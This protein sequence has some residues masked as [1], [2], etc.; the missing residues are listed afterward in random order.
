MVIGRPL[1]E[2]ITWERRQ[3]TTSGMKSWSGSNSIS[4]SVMIH[5]PPGRS[6]PTRRWKRLRR[7]V[8]IPAWALPCSALGVAISMTSLSMTWARMSEGTRDAPDRP[9]SITL[10]DGEDV[11]TSAALP[12][13]ASIASRAAGVGLRELAG[14]ETALGR[15]GSGSAGRN[16]SE[17]PDMA[18]G[19]PGKLG[20]MAC[21]SDAEALG[22]GGGS[23]DD[24]RG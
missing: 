13:G 21:G 15:L 23:A 20:G 19:A 18:E 22:S 17:A 3:P 10:V 5:H 4:T 14:A 16:G 11:E 9:S 24:M 2:A 12:E 8:T 1:G 7:Q 6:P